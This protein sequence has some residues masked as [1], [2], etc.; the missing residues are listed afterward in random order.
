MLYCCVFRITHLASFPLLCIVMT[1]SKALAKVLVYSSPRVS[2]LHF[3]TLLIFSTCGFVVL[4]SL[5]SPFEFSSITFHLLFYHIIYIYIIYIP[6]FSVK[7][8]LVCLLIGFFCC[9]C[10]WSSNWS[11]FVW[12]IVFTYIHKSIGTHSI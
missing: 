5:C 6:E 11:L 2:T 1:K 3:P 4:L 10:W 12:F 9:F 8:L 7:F